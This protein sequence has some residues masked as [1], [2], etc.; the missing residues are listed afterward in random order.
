M[1]TLLIAE[2]SRNRDHDVLDWLLVAVFVS[3]LSER[4]TSE[5]NSGAL[6][7][8]TQMPVSI[9]AHCAFK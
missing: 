5:D 3:F 7:D 6:N 8:F 2:I 9:T 4:K 1:L